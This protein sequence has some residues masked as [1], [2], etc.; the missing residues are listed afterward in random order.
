VLDPVPA[1]P[2]DVQPDL[3]GGRREAVQHGGQRRVADG[4]EAGLHP[5]AAAG[6]DVV[7]HLGGVEVGVAEGVHVVVPLAQA[8]GVAAERAVDEQVAA[9][10]VRPELLGV[11]EPAVGG[12]LGPVAEHGRTRL[13][14]GERQQL[15][16][17][18]GAVDARP[19]ALVQAADAQRRGVPAHRP[20][21]RRRCPVVRPAKAAR[22]T[23]ECACSLT[24]PS[25][26]QPSSPRASGTTASRALEATALCTSVR[27]R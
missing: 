10:A 20:L 23:A 21:G 18:L 1:G 19:A 15:R 24:R 7:G 3:V 27:A 16:E 2:Q 13:R 4:V 5:G 14:G 12:Q 25:P 11:L 8:G 6:G 26:T 22:R 9:G 17:V